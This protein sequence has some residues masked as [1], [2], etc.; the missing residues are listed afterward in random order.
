VRNS[1]HQIST[2]TQLSNFNN[3]LLNK[4]LRNWY[5]SK[6]WKS[7]CYYWGKYRRWNK[8]RTPKYAFTKAKKRS[9]LYTIKYYSLKNKIDINNIRIDFLAITNNNISY[10]GNITEIYHSINSIENNY[11][12]DSWGLDIFSWCLKLKSLP[13]YQIYLIAPLISFS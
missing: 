4:R 6:R 3:E 1:C 2:K 9:L 10:Q 11:Q 8:F 12:Q 5:Y 7:S 13:V